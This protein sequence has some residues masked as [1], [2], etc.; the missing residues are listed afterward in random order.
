MR[1]V[2]FVSLLTIS[3]RGI[4]ESQ[5]KH[6]GEKPQGAVEILSTFGLYSNGWFNDL[7]VSSC[8]KVWL[9]MDLK[10]RFE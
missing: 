1:N 8:C 6:N 5:V 2:C 10:K 9:L 3:E 7:P 4:M